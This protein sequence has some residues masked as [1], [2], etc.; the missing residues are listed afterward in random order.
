MEGI[1]QWYSRM[2]VASETHTVKRA[3]H[4]PFTDCTPSSTVLLLGANKVQKFRSNILYHKKK[5]R[6]LLYDRSRHHLSPPPQFRHR[7]GGEGNI[8][9]LLAPMV[10]ATTTQKTFGPTDLTSAYSKGIWWHSASNS[11]LPKKRQNDNGW[12][13][14]DE[15]FC[16]CS[17]G[18]K[19]GLDSQFGP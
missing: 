19:N 8:L 2:S 14:F 3:S 17:S 4:S 6:G 7:T 10:S 9:Q 5:W 11:R 13:D 18:F 12:T 1:E 16:V 15:I